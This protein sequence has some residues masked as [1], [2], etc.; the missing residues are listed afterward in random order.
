[1]IGRRPH[2]LDEMCWCGVRSGSP[3]DHGGSYST[4]P[5]VVRFDLEVVGI[6]SREALRNL[7]EAARDLVGPNVEYVFDDVKLEPRLTLAGA[8]VG[9]G[10][11][12]AV[13][14]E[15]SGS[16]ELYHGDIW[17]PDPEPDPE[18]QCEMPMIG[19]VGREMGV[20]WACECGQAW[21]TNA[22]DPQWYKV[23]P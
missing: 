1:M 21:Q 4:P 19:D 15:G 6:D 8:P 9:A 5:Q 18:H 10:R 17:P 14:A 3:M 11:V 16:A 23:S 22:A 13:T 20:R 2:R 7:H 12:A